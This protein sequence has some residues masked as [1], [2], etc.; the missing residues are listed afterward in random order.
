MTKTVAP[1]NAP[2]LVELSAGDHWWCSCGLSKRQ[3]FCDGT[4][5]EENTG[6]KP[7]KVEIPK[8]QEVSLCGCRKSKHA[9]FCD[10]TH[11]LL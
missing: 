10:E 5:E 11:E 8:R 2:Y 3:P 4:H 9:P 1:R 6:M 7:I